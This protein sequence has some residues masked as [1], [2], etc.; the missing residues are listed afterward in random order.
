MNFSLRATH[1][2]WEGPEDIT[3]TNMLRNIFVCGM[4]ASSLMNTLIVLL[5][6][7]DPTVGITAMQFENLDAVL[8]IGLLRGIRPGALINCQWKGWDI[9]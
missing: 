9:Y 3:F 5:L 4:P 6:R 2:H 7:P 1:S 8:I